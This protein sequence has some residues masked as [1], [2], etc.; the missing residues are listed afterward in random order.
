MAD[1]VKKARD[2]VEEECKKPTSKYGYEPF[3]YHFAYVAEYA[4]KLADKLGGDKE[5]VLIA[6]W[7]HDIGSILVGRE[8]HHETGAEI[9]A[10]KLIEWGYPKEKTEL[11][12]KCILNHRGSRDMKRHSIEEQIVAEAD[13]MSNFDNIAGIFKAA[14]VYENLN[15]GQAT[16]AARDKLERKWKKIHFEESREIIRPKYEAMRILLSGY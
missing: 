12:R 7:M 15:Q 10:N 9:A 5:A 8:K 6:A 14:F 13:A 2:Y 11:V 4:G 16:K 3:P 1:F